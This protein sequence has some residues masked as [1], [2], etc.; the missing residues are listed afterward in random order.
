[1]WNDTLLQVEDA[2]SNPSAWTTPVDFSLGTPR[3][4]GGLAFGDLNAETILPTS[5]SREQLTVVCVDSTGTAITSANATGACRFAKELKPGY[6]LVIDASSVS[7]FSTQLPITRVITSIVSDVQLTVD[8]DFNQ[9]L[10]LVRTYNVSLPYSGSAGAAGDVIAN[11]G[12]WTFVACPPRVGKRANGAGTIESSWKQ[13]FWS[14]TTYPQLDTV[15]ITADSGNWD[16]ASG[17]ATG[18][19]HRIV[20]RGTRFL[21]Q[22]GPSSTWAAPDSGGY[23]GLGP[24]I[25]VQARALCP[26]P[27]TEAPTDAHA[28]FAVPPQI[29]GDWETQRVLAL[30]GAG[31][32]G[33]YGEY[34]AVLENSFSE[35]LLRTTPWAWYT[36]LTP[37]TG[38]IRSY[39]KRVVSE[40]WA[41]IE[42]WTDPTNPSAVIPGA[43]YSSAGYYGNS[44]FLTQL[45]TG[46]T[47]TACGQTRTVNSIQ[48]DVEMTIDRPFANGNREFFPANNSATTARALAVRG[49]SRSLP[50]WP[51]GVT[52]QVIVTEGGSITGG[53]PKFKYNV[54]WKTFVSTDD[55]D[56]NA[57]DDSCPTAGIPGTNCGILMS[58]TSW[59][60]LE[61]M[62]LLQELGVY[63]KWDPTVNYTA[64]DEW[65]LHVGDI[66]NCAWTISAEGERY[67][68]DDNAN[69]P[70]CYNHGTCMAI[71]SDAQSGTDGAMRPHNVGNGVIGYDT[72]SHVVTSTPDPD[73]G[74]AVSAFLTTLAPGYIVRAVDYTDATNYVDLRVAQVLSDTTFYSDSLVDF[75]LLATSPNSLLSSVVNYLIL[76]CA[77]GRRCAAVAC[78]VLCMR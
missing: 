4:T 32:A 76:P 40:E 48:S 51:R 77:A 33:D 20:G 37:G 5:G 7:P 42:P 54:W 53:A 47:I 46:F 68:N 18:N 15:N 13:D 62:R 39:G 58:G 22:F 35:P 70:V 21:T 49:L 56:G 61:D 10:N 2:P 74:M 36:M 50:L 65:R 34:D 41:Q 23:S 27:L 24:Y 67:I 1:M 43:Q 9:A 6:L 29:N 52:V 55:G 69:P 26:L 78:C 17:G 63:I 8:A 45:R 12:E 59:K 25:T 38:N 71:S 16:T 73:N 60:N 44:R 75:S 66:Q 19:M 28:R 11:A 31:V 14:N 3:G 30:G 64:F 57:A 72:T